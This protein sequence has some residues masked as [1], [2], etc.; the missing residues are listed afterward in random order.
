MII[1]LFLKYGVLHKFMSCLHRAHANPFCTILV[2]VLLKGGQTVNL[3]MHSLLY[4][5]IPQLAIKK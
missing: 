4:I 2:Y 1:L 5:N 3:N